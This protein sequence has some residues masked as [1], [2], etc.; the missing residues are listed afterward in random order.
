MLIRNLP[1]SLDAHLQSPFDPSADISEIEVLRNNIYVREMK[2]PENSLLARLQ[3]APR[4]AVEYFFTLANGLESISLIEPPGLK[5]ETLPLTKPRA[6]R[7]YQLLDVLVDSLVLSKKS[8]PDSETFALQELLV[9]L[10]YAWDEEQVV[11]SVDYDEK[12]MPSVLRH[13]QNGRNSYFAKQQ[14]VPPSN[15]QQKLPSLENYYREDQPDGSILY[16]THEKVFGRYFLTDIQVIPVLL[17]SRHKGWH[18]KASTSLEERPV[19]LAVGEEYCLQEEELEKDI[20]NLVRKLSIAC[21][22]YLQRG[23]VHPRTEKKLG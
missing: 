4:P 20:T 2:A 13:L 9:E 6:E 10:G 1:F 22:K 5:K 12:K 23:D 18:L 15:L 11:K 8:T 7:A 17:D 14:F 21:H 19:P 16:R 3:K